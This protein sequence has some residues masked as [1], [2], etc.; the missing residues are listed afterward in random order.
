MSRY[1][2]DFLA[3]LHRA[4]VEATGSHARGKALEDFVEYVF[5]Q[6]PSV[7]LFARDVRDLDGSQELDLVFSHSQALSEIPVADLLFMIECK[8][9]QEK[10]SAEKISRFGTKLRSRSLPIGIFVTTAGIAGKAG[11]SAYAAL[12]DEL[13]NGIAIIVVL[14][15]ELAKLTTHG[16][17]T[18]LLRRRLMELR[19]YRGYRTF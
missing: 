17:L 18:L 2:S 10:V 4:C 11:T 5:S 7:D 16:D 1:D 12:R 8:N 3:G 6:L 19:T 15:D 14:A 9:E 13:G